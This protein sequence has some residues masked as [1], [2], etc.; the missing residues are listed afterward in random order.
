MARDILMIGTDP[1]GRGGV[2]AVL[3][4]WRTHGLMSRWSVRYVISHDDEGGGWH[5]LQLAAL[6][7]VE[8][9]WRMLTRQ[10]R[11]VHLHTSS[12]ASFWRKTPLVALAML[13]RLPLI[14]SL[15]GGGFQDFYAQRG[16]VGRTWIRLVMRR[17]TRF[18]VLT[19]GWRRW[20]EF[21]EP[22]AHVAVIPNPVPSWRTDTGTEWPAV[23]DRI[24]FLG[25]VERA[26]G[27]YLL[28]DALAAAHAAGACW[29]LVCGGTGDLEQVRSRAHS[30][31]L[32]DSLRLEGWLDATA[33]LAWLDQCSLLVL[34]SLV[35]NM[36]VVLLESYARA[37]P[38]IASR[39]GGVPDMVI[40]GV[41]GWLCEPGDAEG[42]ADLLIRAWRQRKDLPAMGRL[43]RDR[44]LLLYHP[45][46]VVAQVEA[47]YRSCLA[48]NPLR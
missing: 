16:L 22:R 35:E 4:C 19:E 48:P 43:G 26:K 32:G 18:V 27:I 3:Q 41:D 20:V 10:A 11:L 31:G 2:A 38:V 9:S 44:A 6:A 13:L 25:R 45:D 17:A 40:D 8:G 39:V 29:R 34:P 36:P 47:L 24:L 42:L 14:V 21:V 28:L 1:D 5:K 30:L 46:V 33:K 7:W 12:N 37:R 15:H 23:P